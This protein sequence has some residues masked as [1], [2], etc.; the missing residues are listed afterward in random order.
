MNY[1]DMYLRENNLTKDQISGAYPNAETDF[2]MAFTQGAN[3]RLLEINDMK[4]MFTKKNKILKE[5]NQFYNNQ[6][7]KINNEVITIIRES[8]E[9]GININYALVD[10]NESPNLWVLFNV[11]L[12]TLAT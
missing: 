4:T 10:K 11:K 6:I 5:E 3:K 8:L 9:I 12:L 7:E 2:V 1:I